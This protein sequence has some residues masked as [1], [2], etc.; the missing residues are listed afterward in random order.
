MKYLLTRGLW[1]ALLTTVPVISCAGQAER[2][3]IRPTIKLDLDMRARAA[4][5]GQSNFGLYSA[6]VHLDTE[7][8]SGW[9]LGF[10]GIRRA[11]ELVYGPASSQFQVDKVTLEKEWN[12]HRARVGI[13]RLPF[14]IWNTRETYA[15]GIIDYPLARV[16]YGY[17][18]VDW[19]V[20]GAAWSGG[21]RIMQVEAAIVNG[22][23]VGIW[24]NYH[25]VGGSVVRVQS[26]V[27]S[28]IL[29]ASRWDGH[30][31]MPYVPQRYVHLNGID[32]RYTLSHLLFRGEYLFGTLAE[33]Q[34]HGGYLDVYYRVPK[35]EKWTLAARLEAMRRGTGEPFAKQIT[36]GTRFT[37][38]PNLVLVMNWRRNNADSIYPNTWTPYSGRG[39]DVYFQAYY[40]LRL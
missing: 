40:K 37:A 25:N 2:F 9:K 17:S 19:S 26:Y 33:R 12:G 34:T 29:G 35:Y 15:S 3:R 5:S 24:G 18:S 28:L 36:I 32:A 6:Q 30:I 16:D 23:A 8:G 38:T 13:L 21:S 39:G 1:I 20:P 4:G 22:K 10:E 27:G 14:G 11:K 31:D 7:L